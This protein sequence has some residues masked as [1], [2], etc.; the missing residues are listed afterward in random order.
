MTFLDRFPRLRSLKILIMATTFASIFSI[1]TGFFFFD[2]VFAPRVEAN[3]IAHPE[4]TEIPFD[5]PSSG[6][7]KIDHLIYQAGYRHGVDPRLLHA[8]IWQESKYL[9]RATSPVGA[10]GLMQLMPATARQYGCRRPYDP[11]ENIEAGTRLLRD[12]IEAYE[13]NLSLALAG[14]NAGQGAVERH[15]GVPPYAETKGFVR[16]ITSR[17]GKRFHPVL[18]PPQARLEFGLPSVERRT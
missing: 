9:I 5:I 18:D 11:A 3:P 12:L 7:K 6:D 1:L 14:Y 8:L 10:Q 17:Y 13:G 4:N 16:I 2:I 15:S